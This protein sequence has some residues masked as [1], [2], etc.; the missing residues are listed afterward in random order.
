MKII[1]A[2]TTGF[3]GREVLACCLNDSSVTSIV[4]L[5]RRELPKDYPS[6]AK[7]KVAILEDFTSYSQGVLSEIKGACACIW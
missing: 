7:L 5:S 1:L 3:V 6:G 2:G 4:V